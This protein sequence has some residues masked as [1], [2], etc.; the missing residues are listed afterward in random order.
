MTPRILYGYFRSSA[1]YRVRIAL[2]VK[3]LAYQQQAVNLRLGQ[4]AEPAFHQL[5]PQ[6]LVPV[7]LDQG[8]V[9]TQS[10]AICEYLDEAYPDTPRLLPDS[11]AVRARVRALA[12]SIAS[13]IHPLNNLRVLN[14]LEQQHGQDPAGRR[15]WIHHWL[16]QGLAAL[17]QQL[18][19]QGNYCVPEAGLSLADV[20]LVPQVFNARRFELPLEPYPKLVR[21]DGALC[22][23]SSFATAHPAQQ[24]DSE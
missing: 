8:L 1:A 7:L 16:Q 19:E 20:C 3:G 17:E 15:R 18:P 4:Q 22:D 23:L 12:Q 11:V 13:E 5:N 14:Y 21:I 2:H 6:G 10:M 24:P 9:L